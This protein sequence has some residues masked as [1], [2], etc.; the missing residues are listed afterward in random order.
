[1]VKIK[2]CGLRTLIDYCAAVRAGADFTGFVF[3]RQSCRWVEP[4]K[5]AEIVS[6]GPSGPYQKVGVFVNET[7]ERVQ[8]IFELVK[9]NI[10]QLHG[11]ETPDYCQQLGLPYWKALRVKDQSFLEIMAKYE[12][13]VFLLDSYSH[14]TYGGTGLAFNLDLARMAIETG[15]KIV[16][17]GGISEDNVETF[18]K[19]SPYAVDISSSIEKWPGEKDHQKMARIIEKIKGDRR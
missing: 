7:I 13:S 1:M 4:E 14:G 15:R 6:Q 19:L 18:L 3:F 5:A 9:L 8:K 16:I 2:I 12:A 10:V 11:D 17:A